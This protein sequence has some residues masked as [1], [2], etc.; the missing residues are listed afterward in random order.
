MKT[1][2]WL[3]MAATCLA[4]VGAETATAQQ[5]SITISSWG[6]AFQKAQREAWFNTVEKELGITIKEETT[7]GVQD[8]RAQVASGKPTW[9]LTTQGYSTCA[10]LEKEGRLEKLDPAIVNDPGVPKDLK[11]D[12]CMSQI[13]YS[14]AIG[15]RKNAKGFGDKQ[16]KGW[17]S[18]WNVKDFPGQR[19]MRRHPIYNMEA[20]LIADGVPMDKLYPL[21]VERAFK[22]LA[23]LKPHVG[24]WWNSGAQSVQV[25]QDGEVEMVGAWNGRIQAAM[26]DK[27]GRGG[28][29]AITFDQQMLVSD[30]WMMPKGAPNKELAMKALAIMMRPDSQA[31]ISKHINY[32]PANTK[33]YDTGI[34][35]PEMAAN[36]PNS[37]QNIG[38]GFFLSV[39][40]WVKNQDEMI[41]RFDA[42][43]Q[44]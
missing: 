21:D 43:L 40:W 24:V 35:T 2:S 3:L 4:V 31:T 9:D 36:L 7:Q 20:A 34:I 14:V 10:L 5:K 30:A 8:V 33:G 29:L 12:Y 28:P 38:K 27:E 16:P 23:S 37:P 19:S 15:W 18:F 22:K 26:A 25:M 44:Q 41:K 13:V 6:G 39:D 1:R 42:F 11:S 17:D 32:A